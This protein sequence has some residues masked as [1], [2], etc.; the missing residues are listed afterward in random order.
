M[1]DRSVSRVSLATSAIAVA[2]R[3]LAGLPLT[4][5]VRALHTRAGA[6]KTAVIGLARRVPRITSVQREKLVNAAV[7]LACD[8]SEA[9]ARLAGPSDA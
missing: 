8:A 4:A 5:D 6:L 1:M 3:T 7:L 2:E 9:R